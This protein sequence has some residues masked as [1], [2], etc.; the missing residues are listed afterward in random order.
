MAAPVVPNKFAITAPMNRKI[1]FRNG[2]DS[3]LT[4]MWMPPE[5]T[6]SEPTNA[7]KLTYSCAVCPRLRVSRNM[8]IV[9]QCDHAEAERDLGVMPQP[10]PGRE[11]RPGGNRAEQQHERNDQQWMRMGRHDKI[12]RAPARWSNIID[13]PSRNDR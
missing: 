13:K 2:V 5:T 12:L 10:P 8:K 6:Y 4:P 11:H 9:A 3:P 1:T 7:M